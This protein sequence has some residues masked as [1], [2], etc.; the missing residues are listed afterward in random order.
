MLCC[1]LGLEGVR[2]GS[3]ISQRQ[4]G[5]ERSQYLLLLLSPRGGL[6]GLCASEECLVVKLLLST[7]L[8]T[9][10][11]FQCCLCHVNTHFMGSPV[12]IFY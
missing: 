11:Q 10:Y 2:V 3:E 6:A 5:S 4:Q 1:S 7:L 8:A 9:G 12:H